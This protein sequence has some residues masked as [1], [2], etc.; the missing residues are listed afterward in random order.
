[1]RISIC[2]IMNLRRCTLLSIW[3][4]PLILL[5]LLIYGGEVFA[6]TPTMDCE[7]TIA[8][9][10]L[11]HPNLRCRCVNGRPVCDQQAT[12][13]RGG[14]GGSFEQQMMQGIIQSLFQGL[15]SEDRQAAARERERQR[16]LQLQREK[17]KREREIA[18]QR[19][20]EQ[21]MGNLKGLGSD[22][23]ALKTDP[24][25][26]GG[27][28][29]FGQDVTPR[30]IQTL[31]DPQNDPVIVDLRNAN[32]YIS[33]NIEREK[34]L[35]VQSLKY[36]DPKG[37]GEPISKG[38]PEAYCKKLQIKLDGYINEREKFQ[39]TINLTQSEL[40]VWME[41]NNEALRNAA[42]DGAELILGQ[43]IENIKLRNQTASNIRERLKPYEKRLR[44]KGVDVD[45]YKKILDK[46][47]FTYEH[48]TKDVEDFQSAME[49]DAYIR[50]V[51]QASAEKIAE[52]NA[53]FSAMLNDPSV[54]ACLNDSGYPIV[55]AG[56]ALAGEIFEKKI[57]TKLTKFVKFNDR[58]PYVKYAQFAVDQAYNATDWILS[59]KR[60]CDIN[61]VS[62]KETEAAYAIQRKINETRDLMKDCK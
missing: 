45:N 56:Q 38:L 29:F 53:G 5:P 7:G 60:I 49:Y 14:Y 2:E 57:L 23:L 21:L 35:K 10:K 52:T 18:R 13:S 41:K 54:K 43:W 15:F 30:G 46:R 25:Q 34:S 11:S 51:F 62:G 32:N 20:L 47:I 59:F 4:F 27:T 39:K 3:F 16:Q 61:N 24:V 42:I 55:D 22:T 48:L 9:W 44:A 40:N 31:L 50:D 36:D 26:P 17:E 33:E 19:E 1:M 37:N 12:G 28:P 58:I 6:Q 8:S